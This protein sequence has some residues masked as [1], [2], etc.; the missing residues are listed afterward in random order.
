ME[1][2][3][4]RFLEI[5]DES[6]RIVFF[7]GA[8][9]STESGIPDFRSK[10]G[11]YN[12]HDVQFDSYSP[13]YLLSHSCL[14][15]EPEVFFEFYRQKMDT[16][17]IEP[18]ITHKVLAEL[19]DMGKLTAIV[20]QNIDGLH[21]KAGSRKV[22]EIHGTT[23]HNYCSKCRR[24]MGKDAIFNSTGIPTCP[25]C[26]GMIRPYVTLYEEGLPE[27]AVAGAISAIRQ[28]DCLIVAGTSLNVYPAAS[29]IYEFHG[30]HIVVLNLDPV[31]VS[32]NPD[33]DL[34][35][36]GKMGT[37]FTRLSEHLRHIL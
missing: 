37:V 30:K 2:K 1:E 29:Y 7:G 31:G 3:I 4:K 32:L 24:D 36:Q 12:Q 18:N 16:R 15:R 34:F 13:E 28:A 20:T 21:Q 23:Q 33:S 26:G 9:V 22:Y 17:G 14:V 5:M 27:D 35:I 10:D 25:H 19:E 11:L 6:E 8:G